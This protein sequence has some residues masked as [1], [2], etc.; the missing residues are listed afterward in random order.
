METKKKVPMREKVLRIFIA[1][2]I[3]VLLWFMVNGN[4]DLIISQDFNSIPI[5]ITK[6]E[7]LAA[8][9]LVLAEDKSY[10][11]NLRVKGTDKN[12][13]KINPKEIT[14]EV[15]L[16]DINTKGTHDLEIVVKGLSNSVIIDSMNPTTLQI[17]VDNIIK[18]DMDVGVVVEG[19]PANDAVVISAKSL[20][21]VE[22]Q[23]PEESIARIAKTTA[24]ANVS[25][26][27][28]DT[29]QHLQVMAFDASGNRIN[30][31]EFLP[32]VIK[33]EIILGNTKTVGVIP[34]TAGNPADGYV[35]ANVSVAPASVTIGAKQALV[36][37]IQSI[38]MNPIDVSGQAKTFT[39]DVNLTPPEGCYFLDGN[40]KVKVTV[41]IENTVERSFAVDKISV[42]NLGAGLVVSKMKDSKV[43]LK[44]EGA[45]SVLNTLNLA[46]TEA[47]VDC[48]NLGPGEY[49]LPIQTN[50]AQSLVKSVTPGKT[51][52]TI[53]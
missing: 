19:Q 14:A 20:E 51:T 11:L 12:L 2:S 17:V 32:S 28:T 37:Q 53:V 36:D 39:K 24:T 23:G 3:A 13:R 33:A 29:I 26:L 49:E 10:Y 30:D 22:V 50:L 21:T 5:T 18:E 47:F 44:L 46:Q 40:D 16:G 34:T 35:V 43:L 48:A 27:E 41:N 25:D 9:N 4:S 8:K 42:K 15:N 45:S 6:A 38:T 7:G 1:L 52:V 31:V